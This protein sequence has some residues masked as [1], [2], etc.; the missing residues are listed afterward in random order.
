MTLTLDA[1][2][3]GLVETVAGVDGVESARAEGSELVVDL[4]DASAKVA[5]VRAAD[6]RA[7]VEDIIAEEASLESMF[8]QYASGTAGD[9]GGADADGPAGADGAA[10]GTAEGVAR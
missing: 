9:R 5:V 7:T 8:E 1:V 2:P 4:A 3:E 10:E 6:E